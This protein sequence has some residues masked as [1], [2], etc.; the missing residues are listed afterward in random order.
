MVS[1][2]KKGMEFTM[3][4]RDYLA[5][6]GHIVSPEYPLKVGFS[7]R[8]KKSHKFD[9]GSKQ[10]LVE[11][12]NLDWTK[13]GNAPS[14]KIASVNETMIYFAT[15]PK[16]YQKLFFFSETEKRVGRIS[17]TLGEHYVRVYSHFIPDD[18]EI[19][20]LG[21]ESFHPK[22]LWSVK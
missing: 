10:I 18:V 12:K 17:E 5:R 2:Y 15:V 6:Q 20:E 4:V 21:S 11:C 9:L 13:S 8:H 3:Q 19:Y 16:E 7:S 1:N 22:L 14:A